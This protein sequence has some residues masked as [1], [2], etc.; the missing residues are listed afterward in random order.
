MALYEQ[1]AADSA[2]SDAETHA[3]AHVGLAA[4]AMALGLY[5]QALVSAEVAAVAARTAG[6]HA[7]EA[8]GHGLVA[9]LVH[10][11]GETERATAALT[12]ALRLLSLTSGGPERLAAA[13]I[14]AEGLLRVGCFAAA[15]RLIE[16]GYADAELLGDERSFSYMAIWRAYVE[17]A[18]AERLAPVDPEAGRRHR[19]AA[20]THGRFAADHG[21]RVGSDVALV[22]GTVYAAAAAA[23]LEDP[24]G[25]LADLTGLP[26]TNPFEQAVALL[27]TAR[28]QLALGRIDDADATLR[29]LVGRDVLG[30][31]PDVHDAAQREVIAVLEH[32]GDDRAAGALWR[33]LYVAE[34]R[35]A[36]QEAEHRAIGIEAAVELALTTRSLAEREHALAS[37]RD[38]SERDELTGL[39]NRRGLASATRHLRAADARVGVLVIDVDRFKDV[40]DHHGHAVGDRVLAEVA[41]V[42]RSL[43]RASD[44]VCRLG[45]DEFVIVLSPPDAARPLA[46]RIVRGIGDAAWHVHAPGLAITIS[47]GGC[48]VPSGLSFE[49]LVAAA[50]TALYDAKAAGRNRA[51]VRPA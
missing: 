44:V 10:R 9:T 2:G 21:R 6:H 51:F 40:N 35:R 11:L 20:R 36:L 32:R 31:H 3:R 4:A 14:C 24:A 16:T 5:D 19:L 28:A 47:V 22:S 12:E 29:D 46:E 48:S 13:I 37:L 8:H 34:R 25:A 39:L 17:L 49:A 43:T 26:L 33:E 18:W 45:G 27:A 50:D 41:T 7:L 38:L 30:F 42:L 15:H 23:S 1:L